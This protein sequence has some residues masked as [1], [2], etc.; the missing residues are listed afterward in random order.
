MRRWLVE[1]SAY[2]PVTASIPATSTPR[3]PSH[4]GRGQGVDKPR[5][6]AP[7]HQHNGSELRPRSQRSVEFFKTPVPM[8]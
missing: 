5:S 3:P 4:E 8:S 1:W 7:V 2:S 6:F